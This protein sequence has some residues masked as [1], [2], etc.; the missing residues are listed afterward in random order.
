MPPLFVVK[1][2]SYGMIKEK[3][4]WRYEAGKNKV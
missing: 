4:W 3:G 2:R 1:M